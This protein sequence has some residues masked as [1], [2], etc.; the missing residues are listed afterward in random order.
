MAFML[1][2]AINTQFYQPGRD[3]LLFQLMNRSER[4]FW[5]ARYL[6]FYWSDLI[7]RIY[8]LVLVVKKSKNDLELE[9]I[10]VEKVRWIIERFRFPRWREF[11]TRD[12]TSSCVLWRHA[13]GMK[14]RRWRQTW[15]Q[16][17]WGMASNVWPWR[18]IQ[19]ST[20][21]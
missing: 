14:F 6:Y 3:F 18:H 16:R 19:T 5:R 4:S 21:R 2:W 9:Q 7:W 8:F 1:I 13:F 15:K 17:F 20:F 12:I 11:W 10:F